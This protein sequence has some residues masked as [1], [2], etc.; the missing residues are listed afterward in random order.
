MWS[1]LCCQAGATS[2]D[3]T[4]RAEES[5]GAALSTKL[6]SKTEQKTSEQDPFEEYESQYRLGPMSRST[7]ELKKSRHKNQKNT[8]TSVLDN[9]SPQTSSHIKVI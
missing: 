1:S 5:E 7:S 8:T 4:E 3:L 9:E 2:S 6:E